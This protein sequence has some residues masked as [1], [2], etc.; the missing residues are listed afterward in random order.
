MRRVSQPLLQKLVAFGSEAIATESTASKLLVSDIQTAGRQ[1]RAS[2]GFSSSKPAQSAATEAKVNSVP[3]YVTYGAVGAVA[4]GGLAYF[5]SSQPPDSALAPVLTKQDVPEAPSDT[6]EYGKFHMLDHMGMHFTEDSLLGNFAVIFFGTI[7]HAGRRKRLLQL[8]EA[9][10]ESDRKSNMH[11]LIPVFATLDPKT[12][13][14]IKMNAMVEDYANALN[15][16][17]ILHVRLKGVSGEDNFKLHK[18]AQSYTSKVKAKQGASTIPTSQDV[19]DFYFVNPEGEFVASYG[20]DADP[21]AVGQEWAEVMKAYKL[22][23][24]KSVV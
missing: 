8:A 5:M 16:K 17:D 2:R 20:P 23:D 13:D 10:M 19:G 14:V 15:R 3:P 4:L 24:R 22:R 18:A 1:C 6:T 11:Y 12:D 21:K 7:D 9:V